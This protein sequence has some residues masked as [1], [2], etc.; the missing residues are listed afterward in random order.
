MTIKPVTDLKD[1]LLRQKS[2]IERKY[3][4]IFLPPFDLPHPPKIVQSLN[5]E[6]KYILLCFFVFQI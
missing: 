5:P 1:Y 2:E 4:N 6:N 3:L